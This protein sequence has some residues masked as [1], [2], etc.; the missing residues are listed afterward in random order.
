VFI[1]GK[2]KIHFIVTGY[3]SVKYNY[4]SQN[5]FQYLASVNMVTRVLSS[6]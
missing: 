6:A 4:L 5:N 3:R 2:I 1:I